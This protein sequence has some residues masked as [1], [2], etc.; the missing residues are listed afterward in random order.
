[1]RLCLGYYAR[2]GFSGWTRK[3]QDI[4]PQS[5]EITDTGRWRLRHGNKLDVVCQSLFPRPIRFRE[6]WKQVCLV[7]CFAFVCTVI[8]V[9][10]SGG[11]VVFTLNT[12]GSVSLSSTSIC[13]C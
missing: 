13:P 2:G 11:G 4:E 5:V 9:L 6:V 7:R 8:V 3:E 10:V 12:I 1:M